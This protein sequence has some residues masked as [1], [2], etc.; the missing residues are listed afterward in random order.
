MV[1]N[2]WTIVEPLKRL[3][4][5]GR[6]RKNDQKETSNIGQAYQPCMEALLGS[7]GPGYEP[8]NVTDQCWQVMTSAVNV[9]YTL[10]HQALYFMLG[11]SRGKVLHGNYMSLFSKIRLHFNYNW[12]F[13]FL[14]SSTYAG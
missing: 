8:C 4:P 12:G 3:I 13:I 10:T 5:L 1:K 2:K 9:G 7:G 6:P 14:S 11:I